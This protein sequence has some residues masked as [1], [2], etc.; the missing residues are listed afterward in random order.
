MFRRK[1]SAE[2]RQLKLDAIATLVDNNNPSNLSP[3]DTAQKSETD[4]CKAPPT[5]FHRDGEKRPAFHR[6][7]FDNERYH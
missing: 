3:N 7:T 6:R 4:I 2:E 5:T 1:S